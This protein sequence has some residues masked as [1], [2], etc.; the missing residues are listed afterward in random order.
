MEGYKI[1]PIQLVTRLLNVNA[2]D[3]AAGR[4]STE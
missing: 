1:G 2:I 4:L 3:L